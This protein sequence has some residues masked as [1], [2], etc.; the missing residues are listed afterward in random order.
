MK[1]WRDLK[2]LSGFLRHYKER[3]CSSNLH[4]GRWRYTQLTQHTLDS[5]TYSNSDVEL[6][7]HW[8]VLAH[9]VGTFIMHYAVQAYL[10]PNVVYSFALRKDHSTL[11]ECTTRRGI[12]HG[13][14]SGR[15]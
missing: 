10:R 4:V 14:D 13:Q 15:I 3:P 6:F 2:E 1:H 9:I 5:N 12:Q 7:M 11:R 8:W